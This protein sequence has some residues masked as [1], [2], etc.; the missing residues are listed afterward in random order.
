MY[1]K[2]QISS[3]FFLSF[4]LV[5]SGICSTLSF[6]S[7]FNVAKILVFHRE[8]SK[9][10]SERT[11]THTEKEKQIPPSVLYV[12]PVYIYIYICTMQ[13]CNTS[14]SLQKKK[15]NPGHFD[16]CASSLV[17]TFNPHN[18]FFSLF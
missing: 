14:S 11:N 12:R 4:L 1:N 6:F 5:E 9:K 16:C 10:Q 3:F 17:N 15:K 18:P 13:Q 2:S 8:S 7:F